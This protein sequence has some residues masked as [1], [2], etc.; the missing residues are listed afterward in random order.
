MLIYY[1]IALTHNPKVWLSSKYPLGL[2]PKLN[3]IGR[4]PR[5]KFFNDIMLNKIVEG[6]F[7]NNPEEGTIYANNILMAGQSYGPAFTINNSQI[8][9][10]IDFKI[11]YTF[12]FVAG[13]ANS[14]DVGSIFTSTT[15]NRIVGWRDNDKVLQVGRN[16]IDQRSSNKDTRLHCYIIR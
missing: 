1:N 2:F 7:P 9:I 16:E 6:L 13:K 10:N 3:E 8:T 5:S 15:P 4:A 11:D 14:K 12:I